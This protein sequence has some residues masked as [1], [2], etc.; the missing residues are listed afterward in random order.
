MKFDFSR[1]KFKKHLQYL[2]PQLGNSKLF[3]KFSQLIRGSRNIIALRDA[4]YLRL[5]IILHE[6]VCLRQIQGLYPQVKMRH[7]QAFFAD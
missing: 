2:L 1:T 4:S 3:T 7:T 6:Q 5:L